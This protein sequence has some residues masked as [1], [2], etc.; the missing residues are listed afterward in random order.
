MRL[1]LATLEDVH[2]LEG[3]GRS[4]V[5]RR[6]RPGS[7][8]QC[9]AVDPRD[10]QTVFAGARGG[11]LWRT[12][13]GGKN[14][15][16]CGLP[17]GD[18]FSVAVS[19]ASGEVY[20]GTE[21]SAL[22][23]SRDGGR[24]WTELDA[25]RKLPSAPTWSFPPRPWTSHVRWI[26]PCPH[27]PDLLLAGIELGGLMRTTDRGRTWQDHRPGAQRDVHCLAWHPRVP[28][29]A[30]EAAGGGAAFS[31][32]GGD[33]WTPADQGRELSYTWGLAVDPGDPEVWYLSAAAN[34]GQ[35]HRSEG[36][37]GARI[38][39]RQATGWSPAMEG[40]EDP[41]PAFPYAL[42]H[43]EGTLFAGLGDGTLLARDRAQSW[44]AVP[45]EGD[46]PSVIATLASGD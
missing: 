23:A 37:A 8:T 30:Y 45:I 44:Q 20:A 13:D 42:L 15:N 26:A 2:L 16:D 40:L 3:D 28:G 31:T 17:Q 46:R 39:R 43:A 18:V 33:T 11:G 14:W 41:L 19:A 38:Y 32:D 22:F 27:D 29:R 10:R 4:F 1:W 24:T 7:G 6:M 34:A 5:G 9:L 25:L 12:Q 21:P 36:D 35:A